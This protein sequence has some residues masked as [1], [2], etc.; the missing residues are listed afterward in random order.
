MSLNGTS[1]K[2]NHLGL[3]SK[4]KKIKIVLFTYII[5]HFKGVRSTKQLELNFRLSLPGDRSLDRWIHP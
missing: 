4:E 2:E 3:I 5:N 1:D